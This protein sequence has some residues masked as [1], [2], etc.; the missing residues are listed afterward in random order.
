MNYVKFW[1]TIVG[2]LSVLGLFSA[3]FGDGLLNVLAGRDVP[4]A[5]TMLG[6]GAVGLTALWIVGTHLVHHLPRGEDETPRR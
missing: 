3:L 6:L 2:G 4:A 5:A 1:A